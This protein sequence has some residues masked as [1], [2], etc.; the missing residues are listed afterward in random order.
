[1]RC[2][3]LLAEGTSGEAAKAISPIAPKCRRS[4]ISKKEQAMHFH[5]L[6]N[7]TRQLM[8]QELARDI[9]DNNVY[10]SS[11][12]TDYGKNRWTDILRG[13]FAIGSTYLLADC[14]SENGALDTDETYTRAGQTK[15]RAMPKNA[16]ETLAHGEFN[17]YYMRALCL[18][19][20][21][22]PYRSL[23]LE[24]CRVKR[25]QSPREDS[26][27]RI[28]TQVDPA[29]MLAYLRQMP[30]R[31]HPES[32]DFSWLRRPHTGLGLRLVRVE[33]RVRIIER[34]PDGSVPTDGSPVFGGIPADSR[35]SI[36]GIPAAGVRT[37]SS[38]VNVAAGPVAEGSPSVR[39][40]DESDG[41]TTVLRIVSDGPVKIVVGA[42]PFDVG[43]N[44]LPTVWV[45]SA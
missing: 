8:A 40:I 29:E 39:V 37:A 4:L 5:N 28:G 9:D 11:R 36:G 12:L 7:G 41:T 35:V 45:R 42:D 30:G 13:V 16:A 43:S 22:D 17:R 32:P 27:A 31:E 34:A 38:P 20:L 19:A 2:T 21:A 26:Q 10:L 3:A 23:A 25:V 18:R 6:D 44:D 24:V 15:R 33:P 1:M 14:L